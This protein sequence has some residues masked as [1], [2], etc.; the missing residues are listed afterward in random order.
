MASLLR[1]SLS[2]ALASMPKALGRASPLKAVLLSDLLLLAK[3]HDKLKCK[4]SFSLGAGPV[5]A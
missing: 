3:K 1:P 2:R 5:L 4:A